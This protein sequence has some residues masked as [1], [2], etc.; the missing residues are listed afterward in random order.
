MLFLS[1]ASEVCGLRDASWETWR[2]WITFGFTCVGWI[3]QASWR[4]VH[5]ART[6]GEISE[7]SGPCLSFSWVKYRCPQRAEPWMT[8]PMGSSNL[9]T[10]C[11]FY[12]FAAK[13]KGGEVV[14][15]SASDTT[16]V[17]TLL[18]TVPQECFLCG[19]N[20][21]VC[22]SQEHLQCCKHFSHIISF[23]TIPITEPPRG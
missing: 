5:P 4:N 17:G 6:P 21:N 16:V 18:L 15:T 9:G 1:S 14:L 2:L 13:G 8:Y 23:N 3:A 11:F 22:S 10:D 7:V 19:C 20:S 12:S